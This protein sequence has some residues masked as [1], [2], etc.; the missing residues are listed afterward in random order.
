VARDSDILDDQ[1]APF[2]GID[3][4]D[5]T[6]GTA[7]KL[8]PYIG[9]VELPAGIV[10]E[11]GD[12]TPPT[13]YQPTGSRTYY[14]A[15]SSNG[16]LP[17]VMNGTFVANAT[18]PL[19]RLEPVSSIRRIVEDHIGF[20]GYQT[21]SIITDTYAPIVPVKQTL[22][23]I[24]STIKLNAHVRK[25]TLADVQLYVS[26][27]MNAITSVNANS[28]RTL[29]TCGSPSEAVQDI[30]M[31]NDGILFGYESRDPSVQT[32]QESWS[33]SIRAPVRKRSANK[34]TFRMRRMFRPIPGRRPL[35]MAMLWLSRDMLEDTDCTTRYQTPS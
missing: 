32:Q 19:L 33:T 28:G 20:D 26:A 17:Q 30:A 31:R 23:D 8:D 29:Y 10:K 27:G 14:L 11:T 16:R 3:I 21:G 12:G 13:G 5:L 9:S 24:S 34:T 2:Q 1:A 4:D 35:R 22:I 18:S 6:R 15:V 7:G 25:F